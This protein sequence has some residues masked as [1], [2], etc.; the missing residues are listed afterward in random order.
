MRANDTTERPKRFYKQVGVA[1][2]DGGFAVTLDG[3]TP[4]TPLGSKLIVPSQTLARLMADEWAAQEEFIVLPSMGATRLAYTVIDMVSKARAETAAEVGRYAG[5][6]MICYF[7]EAPEGLVKLQTEHWGPLLEWAYTVLGLKLIKTHGIIHQPQPPEALTKAEAMAA[8][9][10]GGAYEI[11]GR[12]TA[13]IGWAGAERFAAG[14]T[15]SLN[16]LARPRWPLDPDA[17]PVRGAGVKA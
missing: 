1:E 13:M 5:S 9:G 15:D 17:E 8:Q 2:A 4:K 16:A 10:A 7:A 6:D 14:L 11:S 3:R 12:M